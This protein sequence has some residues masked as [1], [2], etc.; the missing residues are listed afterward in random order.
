[1]IFGS[2]TRKPLILFVLALLMLSFPQCREEDS[3]ALV[4]QGWTSADPVSIPIRQRLLLSER[5]NL[6]KN[7]SFEHGRLINLDSNTVTFNITGWKWLGDN[8]SWVSHN[9]DSISS[10]MEVRTGFQAVKI[11][12]SYPGMSTSEEEGTE[13]NAGGTAHGVE[14]GVTRGLEKVAQGIEV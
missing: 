2:I 12:R 14:Q 4:G 8:V 5:G 7:P 3:S 1:M 10:R 11:H 9:P 6:V 13:D